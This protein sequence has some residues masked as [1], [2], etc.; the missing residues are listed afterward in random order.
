VNQEYSVF[1]PG[2]TARGPVYGAN[3]P[4]GA[5]LSGL[6]ALP[7]TVKYAAMAA[8]LYAGY[9]KILPFGLAGGAAA[10]AAIYSLF[11]DAATVGSGAPTSTQI[12]ASTAAINAPIDLTSDIQASVAAMTPSLSGF[13][14]PGIYNRRI[15]RR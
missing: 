14:N 7:S 8:A 2:L 10:A 6:P 4:L 5:Y 12:A 1:M 13:F 9:A 11:P 3:S 15:R